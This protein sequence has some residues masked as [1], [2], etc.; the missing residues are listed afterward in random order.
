MERPAIQVAI[1]LDEP[2]VAL[3]PWRVKLNRHGRLQRR[4]LAAG[5]IV[6]VKVAASMVNDATAV[7]G[8]TAGIVTLVLC[9]SLQAAAICLTGIQVADAL[10]IGQ[11]VN[12]RADPHRRIGIALQGD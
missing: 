4:A 2:A 9:M 5:R 8:R 1:S 12:P 7:S 3:S 10:M 6:Q 11:K